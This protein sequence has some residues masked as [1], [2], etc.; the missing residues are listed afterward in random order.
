MACG[1]SAQLREQTRAAHV[2]AELAFAL[3]ERL[4]GRG[5]YAALL[6]ALRG[7][8]RPL[9][10]ALVDVP[11]WDRLSPVVDVR[12]RC[13]AARLDEDLGRLGWDGGRSARV[14]TPPAFASLAQALG[15]LYVLEGSAL[16]GQIVARQ[17]RRTLGDDV[18]VGFFA[19]AGRVALSADWR[20][21][22]AALDAFGA[23]DSAIRPTVVAAAQ[24]T[25]DALGA[26]LEQEAPR[27]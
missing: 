16:G 2:A 5:T 6:L 26:W 22:Q 4:T 11:G 24:E 27:R 15:C 25:F 12:A 19:S 9:E 7:F 14:M 1:L 21:L 8:Y 13:R 3:D 18:P 23:A 17:A 20:T 10:T